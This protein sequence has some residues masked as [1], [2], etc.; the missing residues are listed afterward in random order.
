M[1]SLVSKI[2][3]LSP[4]ETKED[5]LSCPSSRRISRIQSGHQ[6]NP[7]HGDPLNGALG[8]GFMC[9]SNGVGKRFTVNPSN[10]LD[11]IGFFNNQKWTEMWTEPGLEFFCGTTK[12]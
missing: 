8:G 3:V 12:A 6:C 7:I 11:W 5:G 4:V 2:E 9:T 10:N 1:G